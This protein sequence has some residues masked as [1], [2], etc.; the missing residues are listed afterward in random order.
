MTRR[1]QVGMIHIGRDFQHYA[2]QNLTVR[3][4]VHRPGHLFQLKIN[5]TNTDAC[6]RLGTYLFVETKLRNAKL[7]QRIFS[8]QGTKEQ[9]LTS[10]QD[11]C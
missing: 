9:I 10:T 2:W 11:L 4:V 7:H 3:G 8:E 1:Q 6:W 5:S